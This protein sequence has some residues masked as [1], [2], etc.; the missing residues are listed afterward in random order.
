MRKLIWILLL[1]VLAFVAQTVLGRTGSRTGATD[2]DLARK[3]VEKIHRAVDLYLD[4]A[5]TTE[6]PT[7]EMLATADESDGLGYA[8]RNDPWGHEYAIR[9]WEG[10]RQGPPEFEVVSYGPDGYADTEDDV[11][12]RPYR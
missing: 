1:L 4:R 11:S 6:L 7:L 2:M 9:P 10:T 12:S 5:G 3:G 8:M